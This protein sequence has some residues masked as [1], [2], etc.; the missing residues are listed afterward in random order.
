MNIIKKAGYVFCLLFLIFI[1]AEVFL[2]ISGFHGESDKREFIQHDKRLGWSFIPN[3]NVIDTGFEWKVRYSLNDDGIRERRNMENKTEDEYRIL[4]L[5]DSFTE[6]YGIRQDRTFSHLMEDLCNK[7]GNA[8]KVKVINAGVRGYNLTQYYILFQSLYKKYRPD[9]VIIA[10]VDGDLDVTSDSMLLQ[11]K[12][13]YR[14]YRPYYDLEDGHLV[15]KGMPVPRPD[16]SIYKDDKIE[17]LKKYMRKYLA[18][19]T[20]LK[21]ISDRS[22]VLKK[23]GVLLRLKKSASEY[24]IDNSSVFDD[25]E[26][27]AAIVKDIFDTLKKD[28]SELL[29]FL[30]EDNKLNSNSAYYKKLSNDLGFFYSSF[31]ELCYDYSNN[32]RKYHFRFDAHFNEKGNAVIA[33]LLYDFLDKN[34]LIGQKQRL[35]D[36]WE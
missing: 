16:T 28:G 27:C 36:G 13:V 32:R 3:T 31:P 15:V 11:G 4:V 22:V 12:V 7:K 34:T 8:R 9:L 21:I 23:I 33:E 25:K 19:Y 14:Y 6:G 26:V 1:V 17:F 2:R 24:S 29:I 5:G 20:F 18:S 35:F 30:L 10:A